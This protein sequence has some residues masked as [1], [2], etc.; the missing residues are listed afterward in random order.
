MIRSGKFQLAFLLGIAFMA[1]APVARADYPTGAIKAIVP[2]PPG[3]GTDI[4][5]RLIGQNLATALGQPVVIENRGGAE[6]NI[7]MEAVARSAPD[8]YTLLFNSSAATVNPAMYT[9]LR[10]DPVADLVP[11][12]VVC[13][14]Y[15]VIVVNPE[16]VPVKTL[17]EFVEL[18]RK[19]PGK[20]NAAAGGTRLGL[21]IFRLQ[22]NLDVAVIPYR[23]GGDAI[24]A[25]LKGEA[26]FMIV[27]TPG[28]IQ[29]MKA[30]KLRALATT[31][32]QR[33][34]DIPDVPTTREAG[35]PDYTYGSFFAVYTRGG[36]PT[37]V[38]AKLNSTIN[39]ITARPDVI[40]VLRDGGAEAVQRTPE[41]SLRRYTGE[42]AKFRDVV[43]RA[44]IPT[45]D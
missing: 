10:F 33:Q 27:N 25:M 13:E 42:I 5:G 3:G 39:T 43:T 36:T 37:D 17:A 40:K 18:I 34:V 8:G 29:H 23:G 9:K 44:K 31:G 16:K 24:L 30:G 14:Y 12:A 26:D 1:L 20:I 45:V 15:N 2:F 21:D 22:N 7:G 6:G 4:F 11:V 35:M 19:N 32:P 38:I 41:E 28:I